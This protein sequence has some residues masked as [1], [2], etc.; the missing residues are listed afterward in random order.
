MLRPRLSVLALC[1]LV[2]A[3]VPAAADDDDLA[4]SLRARLAA[5]GF[6]GIEID[7]TLFGRLHVTASGN[8]Y[9]REIVIDPDTGEVLRDYWRSLATGRGVLHLAGPGDTLD[10]HDD[11]DDD[12]E[13]DDDD[14]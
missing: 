1:A 13:P 10:R 9:R 4:D 3:A 6:T 11:D 12:D 2:L 5:Q 7:R 8:G 14:D